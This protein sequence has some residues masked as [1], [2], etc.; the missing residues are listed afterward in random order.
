ML[1]VK[2]EWKL[3]ENSE[4]CI[5]CTYRNYPE[6]RVNIGNKTSKNLVNF[7]LKEGATTIADREVLLNKSYYSHVHRMIKFAQPF[8]KIEI[9]YSMEG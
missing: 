2:D 5:H 7:S 6:L 4:I 9:K 8:L 3:F 1:I